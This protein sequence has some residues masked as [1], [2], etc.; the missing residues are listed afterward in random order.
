[1]IK[2]KTIS[3]I[4]EYET[5]LGKFYEDAL[6]QIHNWKLDIGEKCKSLKVQRYVP[7]IRTLLDDTTVYN[8]D[9]DTVNTSSDNVSERFAELEEVYKTLEKTAKYVSSLFGK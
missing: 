2:A 4:D 7:A 1:M 3:I 9:A 5:K 6:H 8:S